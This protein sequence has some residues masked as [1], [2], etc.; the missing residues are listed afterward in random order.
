MLAISMI[1]RLFYLVL[2]CGLMSGMV[3]SGVST[4]AFAADDDQTLG[5]KLGLSLYGYVEASYVQNFNNPASKVNMNRVFDVDSNSFRPHLAQ[6]VL[7]K[8]GKTGGSLIDR[9]GFRI[10][11]DAGEDTEF[12]GG[13]DAT[14]EFDFQEVYAQYI[15]PIGKGID[16][17]LGRM[18]S[19]IGYEVIESP[20][21]PNFS[22]S[23]LFGFGQPFTTTGIRAAYALTDSVSFAVGAINAFNGVTSDFNNSKSV[24][25]A[26][27]LTPMDGLNITLYGFW[28]P[29]GA[30]GVNNADRVLGGGIVDVQAT[31]ALELVVEA[32]YA[33]Q[34][35][36]SGT[37]TANARWNGVAGYVIY[38]FTEQWGVRI[39]G[40]I[41]EDAAGTMSC[42][43]FTGKPKAGACV[44]ATGT[45][46]APRTPQTLWETTFT[47][48]YM[49]VPSLMTRFE[50]RY[51]KSDKNTFQFGTRAA[52]HQETLAAEVVYLF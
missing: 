23:W 45:T 46:S 28:G 50:F 13:T 27:Y 43:G 51:D 11:L 10:K 2:A 7:E 12:T 37:G 39:R 16:L 36:A 17:R 34:A 24:E 19:L 3:W 21:N 44:G 49:P 1:A 5:K 22:R 6:L 14:D 48:Q 26:L 18:N 8:E 35:N 25:S 29:E 20:Y 33:N 42:F 9:V 40:E 30:V 47:L 31:D 52:N 15:L 32:Y 4:P 41:W 38:D